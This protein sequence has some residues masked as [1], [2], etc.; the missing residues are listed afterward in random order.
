MTATAKKE[1]GR[2]IHDGKGMGGFLCPPTH[3]CHHYYVETELHKRPCDR[4]GSSLDYAVKQEWL[5]D[6][7]R[8][9]AQ[10]LLDNWIHPDI[11]GEMIQE[12]ILQVLGYFRGCYRNPEETGADAWHS[13]K[14]LTDSKADPMQNID[15]HAGVNLI[16]QYYPDFTPTAEHFAKAYWGKKPE[17]KS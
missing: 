10:A 6:E 3:P 4:G 1:H 14:L 17:A 13:G 7:T 5:D 15:N 11:D 12:W 2:I 8:Q 16:R 9:A